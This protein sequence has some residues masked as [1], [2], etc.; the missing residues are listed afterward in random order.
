MFSQYE[1]HKDLYCSAIEREH[2]LEVKNTIG[3]NNVSFP[4]IRVKAI[5]CVMCIQRKLRQLTNQHLEI[6]KLWYFLYLLD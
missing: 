3:L 6:Y 4:C 5:A 2:R 1:Y